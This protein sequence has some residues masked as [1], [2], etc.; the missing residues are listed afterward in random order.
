MTH[1]DLRQIVHVD[2][3]AFYA[4]MEQRD[5]PGLRGRPLAVGGSKAR[6]VVGRASYEAW[7]FGGHPAIPS[8]TDRRRATE[9]AIAVGAIS[10][11]LDLAPGLRPDRIGPTV[12][13]T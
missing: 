12:R 2:M 1:A 3:D 9:V 7:Q 6:G 10:R 5:D 11:M 13:G 8:V 4:S